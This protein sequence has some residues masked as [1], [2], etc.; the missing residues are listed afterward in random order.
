LKKATALLYSPVVKSKNTWRDTYTVKAKKEGFPARSVYKLQEIQTSYR[1]LKK[2]DRVLDL[3]C[4]PGSWLLFSSIIVG[5][6]GSVVGI[7]LNPMSIR[8]PA[9]A[10]FYQGD[11]LDL[12]HAL[13]NGCQGPFDVVLSDMA[14]STTGSRL[15]DEQR[16]LRL[17]ESALAIGQ[18]VLRP[19]GT[20]VC[21]IFQGPDFKAFSDRVKTVFKKVVH[22]RPKSTRK[23]SREI[24]VVGLEK[25]DNV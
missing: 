11:V 23:Q 24:F 15:V 1:F 25:K 13:P 20:L 16:S 14:P 19:G 22:V 5:E 8:L 18:A 4:A 7:D 10:E 12:E 21:K 3:G 17:C 6:K 9:N 2:G